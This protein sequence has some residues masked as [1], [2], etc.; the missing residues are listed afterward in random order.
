[1]ADSRVGCGLRPSGRCS[2]FP[3]VAGFLRL[4]RAYT[5]SWNTVPGK[6][7]LMKKELLDRQAA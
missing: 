7:K 2:S 1:M 3:G 5:S 4:A 6:G